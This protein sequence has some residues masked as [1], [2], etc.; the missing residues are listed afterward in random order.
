MAGVT[1]TTVPGSEP[2]RST[3]PRTRTQRLCRPTWSRC[4]GGAHSGSSNSSSKEVMSLVSGCCNAYAS[5]AL[6]ASAQRRAWWCPWRP[7]TSCTRSSVARTDARIS[8]S[9]AAIPRSR[10]ASH[11]SGSS[12]GRHSPA[13]RTRRAPHRSRS[14]AARGGLSHRQ[15]VG[16]TALVREQRGAPGRRPHRDLD[17]DAAERRL[18]RVGGLDLVGDVEGQADEAPAGRAVVLPQ[19]RRERVLGHR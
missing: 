9:S 17:A 7:R 19:L 4:G 2:Q 6:M 18:A 3:L 11:R 13:G 5:A 14:S 10:S 12:T 8:A 15:H 1:L 16:G